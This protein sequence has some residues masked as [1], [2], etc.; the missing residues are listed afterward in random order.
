MQVLYD[1]FDA[2]AASAYV[3]KEFAVL[4]GGGAV[5]ARGVVAGAGEDGLGL[6]VRSG[7]VPAGS[8]IV[9]D[10]RTQLLDVKRLYVLDWSGSSDG[11]DDAWVGQTFEVYDAQDT[12]QDNPT[13]TGVVTEIA[14]GR[15]AVQVT[16]G[17]INATDRLVRDDTAIKATAGFVHGVGI[18]PLE[19]VDEIRHPRGRRHLARSGAGG[20]Q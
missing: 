8:T 12:N 1:N 10:D 9:L 17:T 4:D 16:G 14:D 15:I 5:V 2:T 7:T 19:M 6:M 3:G 18:L 11:S 13:G 20:Q